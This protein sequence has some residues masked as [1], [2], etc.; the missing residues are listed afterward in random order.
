LDWE[1]FLDKYCG[2]PEKTLFHY[3]TVSGFNGILGDNCLRTTDTRYLNDMEEYR[4]GVTLFQEELKNVVAR[5]QEHD[6]LIKHP[7]CVEDLLNVETRLDGKH[8]YCVSFTE[9]GNLLSQWRGYA[10][11]GGHPLSVACEVGFLDVAKLV[12]WGA[13]IDDKGEELPT[14]LIFAAQNG[15]SHIVSWLVENGVDINYHH[16]E[17]DANGDWEWSGSALGEAIRY[18]HLDIAEYLMD[19]GAEINARMISTSQDQYGL[20]GYMIC[21][22]SYPIV[23]FMKQENC[24]LF[25][26]AVKLNALENLPEEDQKFLLEE[27]ICNGRRDEVRLI[28]R[29][30]TKLLNQGM[31]TKEQVCLFPLELAA[32]HKN[33]EIFVL[34]LQEGARL[35]MR[36]E[37]GTFMYVSVAEIWP[38][39]AVEIL[40]ALAKENVAES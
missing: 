11:N 4:H 21:V 26:K 15:H 9:N 33:S 16:E 30:L 34:L 23:E 14:P 37:D 35:G 13:D 36:N 29:K 1:Y 31:E 10:S 17:I 32:M 19:K 6:F 28:A 20:P 22:S 2:H 12:A 8:T 27:C 7:E 25:N 5:K 18:E 3:T 24:Y 38:E 39:K 40:S